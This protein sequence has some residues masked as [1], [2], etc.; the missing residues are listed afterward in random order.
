MKQLKIK[1]N[2]VKSARVRLGY[3][4]QFM[5]D[6]LGISLDSYG[7]KERGKLNFTDAEKIE[8]AKILN[9]TVDQLN[10]VLFEGKLPT[11]N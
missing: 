10:D 2:E 9:M 4:Q 6:S 7:G 11:G 1:P 5:A 3:D 8:L